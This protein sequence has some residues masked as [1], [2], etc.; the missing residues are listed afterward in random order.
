[1]NKSFWYEMMVFVGLLGMWQCPAYAEVEVLIGLIPDKE[2]LGQRDNANGGDQLQAYVENSPVMGLRFADGVEH[3]GYDIEF[4]VAIGDVEV[5]N[6]EGVDF[7]NH[8]NWPVM[9]STHGTWSPVKL[10]LFDPYLQGGLGLSIVRVDLDNAG[11]SGNG[12]DSNDGLETYWVPYWEGG[13]GTKI[14]FPNP[15]WSMDV[16]YS[17]LQSIG[18]GTIE[19]DGMS[20]FTVRVG[21]WF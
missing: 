5:E 17:F 15:D 1:M 20:L 3:F 8:G 2:V 9:F 12:H 13:A 4:A 7:P 16:R 10:W 11:N 19:F 21:L 6:L 18:G 14:A